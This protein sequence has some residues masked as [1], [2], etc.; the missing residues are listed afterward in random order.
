MARA[1]IVYSSRLHA[2]TEE[3]FYI[4]YTSTLLCA[5]VIIYI[6]YLVYGAVRL[7]AIKRPLILFVIYIRG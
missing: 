1:R 5:G 7:I 3:V 2:R 6:Y 4:V